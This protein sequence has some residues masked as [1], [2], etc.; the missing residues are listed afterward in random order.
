MPGVVALAPLSPSQAHDETAPASRAGGAQRRQ[1]M[2]RGVIMHRLLQ[3]LPAIA[4]EHRGEAARRYLASKSH[5]LTAEDSDD[6][7]RKALA[8]IADP[9]F[10]RPVL[11][12]SKA[13]VPIVGRV[14]HGGHSR[15]VAGVVDR[16]LVKDDAILIADFK[17]NR[18]PPRTPDEAPAGYVAQ[19]ALYR[20]LLAQLYPGR[21]VRAA[22]IWTE[23]ADLME[24]SSAA[25]DAA[26]AALTSS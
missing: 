9:R 2:A 13:E 18:N 20:A 15:A 11:A 22:L 5:D 8:L 17:T 16:L 6:L 1:A 23:V 3:S 14:V 4:P 21:P 19:L 7:A 12:R 10:R 25:L 24:I 26:M